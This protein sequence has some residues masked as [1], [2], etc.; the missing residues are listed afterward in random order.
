MNGNFYEMMRVIEGMNKELICKRRPLI[1]WFDVVSF[2]SKKGNKKVGTYHIQCHPEKPWL[3]DLC[4]TGRGCDKNLV[5][6]KGNYEYADGEVDLALT[7]RLYNARSAAD[8]LFKRA[9]DVLGLKDSVKALTTTITGFNGSKE[10]AL[11]I[12][13]VVLRGSLKSI[14][15]FENN[16]L[17]GA[18]ALSWLTCLSL[19]LRVPVL[20]GPVSYLLLSKPVKGV[21]KSF[22]LLSLLGKIIPVYKEVL[23]EL[24]VAGATWVQID[25]PTLV[26]DL[27]YHKLK[28]FTEAYEQLE[29]A[30]SG[31]SV[32]IETY[33]ADLLAEAYKTIIPLKGVFA[34][35]LDLVRGDKTLELVKSLG[36]PSEKYFFAGVVDGGNIWANDLEA[37][38]TAL[39]TL[40]GIVG[41]GTMYNSAST[42]KKV[43]V[44][45]W[46]F[47]ETC[48]FYFMLTYMLDEEIKSCLTFAAQKILEVNA[49]AKAL[50]GEKDESFFS[51]NA[52][53]QASRKSSPRVND[54]AVQKA[55]SGTF[56]STI[57]ESEHRRG[58]PVTARLDAQQKNLNLSILPTTTI[59][60]F[61]QT[62]DLRKVRREY[63]ANKISEEEYIKAM[64]KEISKVVKLQE[65]LDI[66][67]KDMV[68]YFGEQLKGFAF[69]ANGWVQSYGSRCVKLPIIY[70]ADIPRVTDTSRVQRISKD[71]LI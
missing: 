39:K 24:K 10:L 2:Y 27:D 13:L 29:D 68:E 59:G 34:I 5:V 66:N 70:G 23:A 41:K 22:A 12:V 47:I 11:V 60:S 42:I 6:V 55:A 33:F 25:E 35:G 53:S 49:L 65:D 7:N 63:K 9:I 46:I 19:E 45:H 58:T 71:N 38:L 51:A 69:S 30:L 32:I 61:P 50:A 16:N 37:S 17:S 18:F 28:A 44:T 15:R 57:R 67:R 62:P 21:E 14:Q 64:K 26:M 20:V 4:S 36:F 3:F 54:E 31:F 40:E 43:G 52:T 8:V 56:A 48:C 1:E